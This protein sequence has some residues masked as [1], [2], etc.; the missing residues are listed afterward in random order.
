[1]IG[2]EE[3]TDLEI[4]ELSRVYSELALAKE[5]DEAV[6]PEPVHNRKK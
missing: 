1:M 3:K 5:E 2:A 4:V 6:K